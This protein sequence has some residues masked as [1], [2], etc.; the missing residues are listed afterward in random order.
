[1]GRPK[2][3][4]SPRAYITSRKKQVKQFRDTYSEYETDIEKIAAAIKLKE[5]Q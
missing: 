5:E 2:K 4:D 1:M 3:Y